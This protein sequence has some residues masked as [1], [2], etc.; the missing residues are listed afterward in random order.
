MAGSY[1]I[2]NEPLGPIRCGEFLDK[3]RNSLASQEGL[4]HGVSCLVNIRAVGFYFILP[5]V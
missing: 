2:G 5:S 1:E 4:L 3:A